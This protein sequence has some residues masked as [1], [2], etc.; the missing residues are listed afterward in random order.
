MELEKGSVE[1]THEMSSSLDLNISGKTPPPPTPTANLEVNPT[2]TPRRPDPAPEAKVQSR[3]L[4]LESPD[5]ESVGAWET[6]RRSCRRH[7]DSRPTWRVSFHRRRSLA[8][9]A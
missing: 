4:T 2:P 5:T 6:V 3:R 9:Y 7:C 1:S 8:E